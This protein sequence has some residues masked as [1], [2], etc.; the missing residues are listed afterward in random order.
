MNDQLDVYINF[1]KVGKLWSTPQNRLCFKYDNEW[2]DNPDNCQLSISLPLRKDPY[3]DDSCYAYFSNLL[4]EGKVLETLS[5]RLKISITD[6]FGLLRAIG[7]DCAGAISFYP[8]GEMPP[9]PSG[10]SYE[11]LTEEHLLKKII[12]LKNDPFLAVEEKRLSLAGA[13]DKLPVCVKDGRILLPVN[14]APTTHI[15]KFPVDELR[16]VVTNETYCMML[17]KNMGLDVPNVEMIKINDTPVYVIERYDRKI[18]NGQVLRLV[19]EDF[20]QALGKNS[21]Q[22]YDVSYQECFKVIWKEC[23]FPIADSKKLINNIIFNGL[24][25]NSDGHAKNISLIQDAG[26]IRL[27]PF[28]DLVSTHVFER[29]FTKKMPIKIA[30]EKRDFR[31]IQ[32]HHI[33]A[34]AEEIG[35]KASVITNSIIEMAGKIIAVSEITVD[36]FKAKYKSVDMIDQINDLIR[37][38]A[39]AILQTL[40]GGASFND[41]EHNSSGPGM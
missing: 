35:V 13:M 40:S 30:G 29:N 41:I 7:G 27:A 17:A 3:L 11:S 18:Q 14:G 4:P 5:Q 19:Q 23:A 1:Q 10:Y 12:Y 9:D 22:K 34:L 8:E 24:I 39:L 15:I 37:N 25:G 32:T 2:L 6:K 26:G 36:E 20:C 38:Y 33:N 16:G 28:Y 31:Y 21:E